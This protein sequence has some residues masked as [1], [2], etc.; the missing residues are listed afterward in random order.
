MMESGAQRVHECTFYMKDI[1]VNSAAPSRPNYSR[2]LTLHTHMQINFAP[3]NTL[4]TRS[5][6]HTS[7]KYF[8][9]FGQNTPDEID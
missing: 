7:L 1:P 9:Q 2:Y 8:T 6:Q 4:H 5:Y 3:S